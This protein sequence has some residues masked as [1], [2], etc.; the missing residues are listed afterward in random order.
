MFMISECKRVRGDGV[1]EEKDESESCAFS[2][3]YSNIMNTMSKYATRSTSW[4]NTKLFIV[5]ECI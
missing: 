5:C 2:L 1:A 4:V 3:V